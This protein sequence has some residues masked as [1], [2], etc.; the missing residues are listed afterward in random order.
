LIRVATSITTMP[1]T[2]PPA[3]FERTDPVLPAAAAGTEQGIKNLAA[4]VAADDSGDRIADGA[5]TEL[6]R[7]QAADVA[8]EP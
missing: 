1:P 6:F 2:T 5:E 8:P 7:Q 3:T 4:N